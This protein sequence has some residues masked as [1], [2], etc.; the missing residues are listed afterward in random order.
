M[1]TCVMS[2]YGHMET[3]P[4]SLKPSEGHSKNCTHTLELHWSGLDSEKANS[5]IAHP[6][7]LCAPQVK[8]MII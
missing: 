4:R 6:E 8:Y 5:W 7:V 2:M 1:C 3:V